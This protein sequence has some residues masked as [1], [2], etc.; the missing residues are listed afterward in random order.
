MRSCRS[1]DIAE[2]IQAGDED[3]PTATPAPSAAPGCVGRAG[4]LGAPRRRPR[5]RTRRSTRRSASR[6]SPRSSCPTGPT[7]SARPSRSTRPNAPPTLGVPVYTIALGTPDGQVQVRDEAGQ[8][9]HARR[10][11]RHGDPGPDRRDHRRDRV[12]RPDRRGPERGLRQPAVARSATTNEEQEVTSLVRRRRRLCSSWS[13]PGCRRSGS[14]A[15][16]DRR[17]GA[18]RLGR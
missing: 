6:S 1:L 18:V 12:R 4:R 15:C 8:L 14:A 3:T 9:R 17:R 13:R 10:A 11:A 16:P 7:P 5:A 2:T